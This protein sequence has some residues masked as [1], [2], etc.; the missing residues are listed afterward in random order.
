MRQRR[1]KLTARGWGD[2]SPSPHLV[3]LVAAVAVALIASA[4]ASAHAIVLPAASRPAD[5]Q[6]YTLTV[7]NERDVPTISVAL[8]V[9][10]GISFFLVETAPGWTVSIH[11]TDG[12]VAVVRWTG[13]AI[14]V[15]GFAT[16][17]VLARNP[18]AAVP[19][20]WKVLQG[21]AGGE[22]VRWIGSPDSDTPAPVT[23]ITEQ[24]VPTDV[25]DVQGGKV[26]PNVV[27]EAAARRSRDALP[28]YLS[29]VAVV[30]A[31]AALVLTIRRR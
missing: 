30:L 2:G 3:T 15:D 10:A 12:H 8:Q 24:A 5:L 1:L 16:F 27:A 4:V 20:S 17:R 9:P 14:P 13:G 29:V 21:Y 23:E 22:I 18:I 6:R 28:R 19:I 31:G 26:V 25:I 7:P 11:K